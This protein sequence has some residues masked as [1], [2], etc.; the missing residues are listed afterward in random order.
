MSARTVVLLLTAL[1]IAALAALNWGTLAAPTPVSLGVASITAP[2]GLLLL[3]LFALF[4]VVALA[5]VAYLRS[6]VL[7]D[8]R[9][10][11][12]ELAAQRDLADRA[13]ASRI[14]ELRSTLDAA[15]QADRAQAAQDRDRLLARLDQLER[16]LGVRIEQADNS[17][18]AYFGA[19]DDRLARTGPSPR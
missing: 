5:Y 19:L 17:T 16:A 4:A 2:L 13:E 12:K 1:A 14:A 11:A 8:T 3:A 9:R 6:A 15:R 10:H 7:L 18:A